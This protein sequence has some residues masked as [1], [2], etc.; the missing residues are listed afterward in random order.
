M[1]PEIIVSEP[2]ITIVRR[3]N[4]TPKRHK[5]K[6]R[7][8]YAVFARAHPSTARRWMADLLF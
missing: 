4:R 8:Y 6:L 1:F 3:K 2:V 7:R 5:K